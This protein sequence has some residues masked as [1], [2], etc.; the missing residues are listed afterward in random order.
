MTTVSA[1]DIDV[2]A[3]TLTYG[4]VGGA[5]AAKFTINSSTGV[6]SFITA[7]D[8]ENPTD[9]DLNNIY[10]LTV[11]VSDEASP[12]RRRSPSPSATSRTH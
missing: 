6:L 9:A 11:Q 5:D 10:E 12:T 4:I 2:P 3:Q 1:T 7:P 8:F